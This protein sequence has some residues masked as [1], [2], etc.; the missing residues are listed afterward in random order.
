MK[1]RIAILVT[2]LLSLSTQVFAAT[3]A[4]NASTVSPTMKISVNVQ[5]AVQLTLSTGSQ[6]TVG[7][8]SPQD[9]LM[10]FGNVDALGISVPTCGSV[11]APTTPGQTAAVYYSDYKLTPSFSGQSGATSGTVTAYVST[12]FTNTAVLAVVQANAA[13]ASIA[14]LTAMSTTSATPTSVGTT[15]ANGTAITRYVGVQVSVQ[16]GASAFTGADSAVVTYTLTTP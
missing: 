10:T 3:T 14:S 4:A 9:Y 2:T 12:N 11:Y 7:T 8:G 6:C 1:L 5:K 15:L 16:N 13:P